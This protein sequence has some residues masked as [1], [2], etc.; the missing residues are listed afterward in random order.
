MARPSAVR[1]SI[2][3]LKEFSQFDQ[4]ARECWVELDG[5]FILVDRFAT[6]SE[7]RQVHPEADHVDH[8][9]Q[10][11]IERSE[12]EVGPGRGGELLEGEQSDRLCDFCGFGWLH[13]DSFFFWRR[14]SSMSFSVN[15]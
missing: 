10:Q 13:D 8:N 14:P 7:P 4:S 11:D 6:A 12:A 1:V 2:G 5:S 9:E 3:I 15:P